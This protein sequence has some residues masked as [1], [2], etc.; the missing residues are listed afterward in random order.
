M[1]TTTK[2]PHHLQTIKRN[3]CLTL[4]NFENA[5]IELEPFIKKHPFENSQFSMHS[6]AKHYKDLRDNPELRF[7][8]FTVYSHYL[9]SKRLSFQELKWQSADILGSVDFLGNPLEFMNDVTEGLSGLIYEGSVKSL[10]KNVTRGF[11]KSAAKVT[12]SLSDRLGRVI[13]DERHDEGRQRIR[14]NRRVAAS[15]RWPV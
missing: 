9:I 5:T 13:M 15:T 14:A 1:L 2:L 7:A 11:S 4:I 3:L 12:K 8:R 6:I 10:V